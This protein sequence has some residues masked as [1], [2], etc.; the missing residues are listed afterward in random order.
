MKNLNFEKQISALIYIW[1]LISQGCLKTSVLQ[2]KERGNA[3]IRQIMCKRQSTSYPLF[4]TFGQIDH[5]K[6][7]KCFQGSLR[8]EMLNYVRKTQQNLLI[9]TIDLSSRH[10]LKKKIF[11]HLLNSK[12]CARNLNTILS[13]NKRTCSFGAYS[14][15][16]LLC[17]VLE[18][19]YTEINKTD[20]ISALTELDRGQ[21]L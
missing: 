6:C 3:D 21:Y 14:I 20:I 7:P 16:S 10:S 13:K 2:F 8:V 18:T 12:D 17:A 11:K 9:G 4:Q 15:K 1:A 5:S 19:G